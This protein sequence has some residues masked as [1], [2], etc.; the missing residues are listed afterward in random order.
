MRWR[1]IAQKSGVITNDGP[2]GGGGGG[3]G[4]WWGWVGGWGLE[5]RGG[6]VG[7]EKKNLCCKVPPFFFCT[8]PV[9]PNF[10]K[11]KPVPLFLPYDSLSLN[12]LLSPPL[13]QFNLFLNPHLVSHESRSRSSVYA[14]QPF[15]Y[16]YKLFSICQHL[17]IFTSDFVL[18]ACWVL[19]SFPFF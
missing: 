1:K 11:N 19:F 4:G 7:L 6:W 12:S 14:V 15:S 9:P 5:K 16:M 3:G 13:P 10:Q 2:W 18:V 8:E 17:P